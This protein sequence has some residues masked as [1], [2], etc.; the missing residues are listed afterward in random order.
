MECLEREKMID[1]FEKG[2]LHGANTMFGFII[3]NHK[4]IHSDTIIRYCVC[5]K[6]VFIRLYWNCNVTILWQ[7]SRGIHSMPRTSQLFEKLWQ[8]LHKVNYFEWLLLIVM[9]VID[10][11]RRLVQKTTEYKKWLF[12][13]GG[14][15]NFVRLVNRD[16]YIDINRAT[17]SG[18]RIKRKYK[19][20]YST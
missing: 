8:R 11:S 16:D 12:F 1:K 13:M 19:Q 7:K 5:V 9:N 20:I 4:Q 14:D 6:I 18:A 15:N 10:I 3:Q 2:T 17:P